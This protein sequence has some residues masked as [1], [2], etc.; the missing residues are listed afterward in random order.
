MEML[1]SVHADEKKT[2]PN[3]FGIVLQEEHIRMKH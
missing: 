1:R 3:A 2:T